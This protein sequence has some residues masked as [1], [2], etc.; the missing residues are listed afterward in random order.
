MLNKIIALITGR[1]RRLSSFEWSILDLVR[2]HLGED[3][4]WLWDK[5]LSTINKIGRAPEGSE[6]NFYRMSRGRPTFD[7]NIAFPNKSAELLVAEVKVQI[8]GSEEIFAKI[9]CLN[10]FIFSI[11]YDRCP[12]YFEEAAGM[13]AHIRPLTFACTMLGDLSIFADDSVK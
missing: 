11:D 5:Q 9:W 2:N 13:E 1:G 7:K 8:E 3:I 10:G 6:V 4:K 12:D